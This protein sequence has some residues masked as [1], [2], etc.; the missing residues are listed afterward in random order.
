MPVITMEAAPLTPEQK[1][2]LIAEFTESAA[3]I[4]GLDAAAFYVFLKENSLENVGVGG[5]V[6]ADVASCAKKQD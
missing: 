3:R 1:R 2:Q 5:K 6:L 4:T